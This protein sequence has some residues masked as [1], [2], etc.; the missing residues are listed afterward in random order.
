M[1]E[2]PSQIVP[3]ILSDS[4]TLSITEFKMNIRV[5]VSKTKKKT[6]KQKQNKTKR[7]NKTTTKKKYKNQQKIKKPNKKPN[8][9]NPPPKKKKTKKKKKNTP[10]VADSNHQLR[11]RLI[12][13][14]IIPFLLIQE[15][16]VDTEEILNQIVVI[17]SLYQSLNQ[18]INTQPPNQLFSL[19]VF[20]SINKSI[21]IRLIN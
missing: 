9:N 4:L 6:K 16:L 11:H 10:V 17:H 21:I 20:R 19:G 15:D 18:P 7:S 2:I 3:H 13:S 12:L 8:R 14:L 1:E 5:R